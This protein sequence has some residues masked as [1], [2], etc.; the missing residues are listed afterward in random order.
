MG[1][2][3]GED[4]GAQHLGLARTGGADDQAVR[5]HARQGGL[6]DVEVDGLVLGRQADRDAKTI[7]GQP[8]LP[9][10]GDVE[11]ADVPQPQ[12]VDEL[13]GGLA[14]GVDGLARAVGLDAGLGRQAARDDLRLRDADPVS[15]P[16]HRGEAD[17]QEGELH[18]VALVLQL[19]PHAVGVGER[20]PVGGEL[21]HGD[22]ED[23]VGAD[24]GVVLGD[25]DAV[26][27]DDQVRQLRPALV[28]GP[29][30]TVHDAVRQE[31]D[32]V[33]GIGFEH[34][35]RTDRV[36]DAVRGDVRKPLDPLPV[37][38][39]L[40]AGE[41]GDAHVLGVG[42]SG[43]LDDHGARQSPGHVAAARDL[44]PGD[45]GQVDAEGQILDV[46]V[47]AVELRRRRLGDGVGLS[48]LRSLRGDDRQG[49]G[50]VGRS[51]ADEQELVV[52]RLPVS[53][54]GPLVQEHRQIGRV[55]HMPL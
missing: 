15:P 37:R 3:Q 7:P 28:G 48:Q 45:R 23:A 17:L 13:G 16:D 46:R 24:D 19:Q 47:H 6:L 51:H 50:L 39:P 41:D 36:V 9:P 27:E 20:G 32:E 22:P 42:E 38:H 12:E 55:R 49:E 40:L 30:R 34:P 18:V 21:D 54:V 33:G 11:V 10:L 43:R 14:R 29:P 5:A 52:G 1:H 31:V 4:E 53:H 26:V 44:D 35:G 8:R 25:I 2:R